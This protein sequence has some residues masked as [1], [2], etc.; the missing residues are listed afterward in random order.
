MK[1]NEI[2]QFG[3]IL[4]RTF[5]VYGK[6]LTPDML[7]V[8]F[9]ALAAY[10]L[11]DVATALS[12]HLRDADS[13]RFAPKPADVVAHLAGGSSVRA[14]RAWSI[15]EKSVR[16]VGHYQSVQ[17]DDPIIHRV[18]DDMGGWTKLASTATIEDLK[19]RGLEF[20]KRYQG[21][22][23]TGG[24]GTDYPPYLIGAAEA[25]NVGES[26]AVAPTVLIGDPAKCEQV[27]A[28]SQGAAG[29]RVTSAAS[30]AKLAQSAVKRIGKQP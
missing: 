14:L 1:P 28:L 17:F 18:I 12:R 19:F 8:W 24:V 29:L 30:V 15:V 20:Q 22:L 23:I 26:V 2:R 25:H 27:R 7:E 6:E 21:A 5:S 10:T 13:G 3:E 4:R 11:E 16:M 9:D